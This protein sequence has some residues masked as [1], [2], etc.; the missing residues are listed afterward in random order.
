[1][2]FD[3]NAFELLNAQK[4]EKLLQ[5]QAARQELY[6][7]KKEGRSTTQILALLSNLHGELAKIY[8]QTNQVLNG[9]QQPRWLK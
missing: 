7:L 2:D 1:M 8:A 9:S 4:N 5:I 3:K 6:N